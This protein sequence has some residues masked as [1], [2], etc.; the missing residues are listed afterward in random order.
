MPVELD[1]F[2]NIFDGQTRMRRAEQ[3]RRASATRFAGRGDDLNRPIQ[4]APRSSATSQPVMRT[5][6]TRTRTRALLQ[7][8]RRRRAHRGAGRR[9][10]TRTCSPTWPTRSRRGR[11]TR[12]RSRTRSP[13][14]PS[15]LDVATR[16]CASSARS[17]TTP[18]TFTRDLRRRRQRAA[19][20]RCR[21]STRA[22]ETGIAGARAARSSSTGDLQDDARTRCA[23]SPRRP[24]HERRA[25]RPDRHGGH[26]APAAALP[27]ART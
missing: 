12:R 26:A 21:R 15:T 27:R 14:S 8:A 16:R 17:W 13:S 7:R 23:T 3:P 18:P 9:A 24:T 11:A 22:L 19:R 6:P 4:S 10:S 5:S 2:Y 25:A 1:E 20:A